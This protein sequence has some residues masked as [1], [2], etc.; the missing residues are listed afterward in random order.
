[1]QICLLLSLS[2]SDSRAEPTAHLQ[3]QK[4]CWEHLTQASSPS[5][6]HKHA[7]FI[8][9]KLLGNSSYP[10]FFINGELGKEEKKFQKLKWDFFSGAQTARQAKFQY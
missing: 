9:A 3:L 1:M 6:A 7:H 4:P 5:G 2:P 8:T 10:F